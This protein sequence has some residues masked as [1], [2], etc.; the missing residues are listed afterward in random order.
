MSKIPNASAIY[1][2]RRQCVQAA[3][4]GQ[5]PPAKTSAG[6]PLTQAANVFAQRRQQVERAREG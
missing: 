5:S 3:R 4:A 2:Y 1:E 6:L